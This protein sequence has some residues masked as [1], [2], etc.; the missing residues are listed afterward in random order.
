MSPRVQWHTSLL[1]QIL[2]L[3]LISAGSSLAQDHSIQSLDLKKLRLPVPYS[4]TRQNQISRLF[5]RMMRTVV[6]S[7]LVKRSKHG[8]D[9]IA[10]MTI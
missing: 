5:Q 1:H 6:D 3:A 4:L 2:G 8:M 10:I 9:T 7:L